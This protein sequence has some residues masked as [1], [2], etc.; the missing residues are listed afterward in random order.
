MD[1]DIAAKVV[2]PVVMFVLGFAVSRFTM[3]KKERS[4]VL[5]Q[6]QNKY[7]EIIRGVSLA[8]SE[9]VSSIAEY[10]E[11]SDGSRSLNC[12]LSVAQKGEAYFCQMRSACAALISG[13]LDDKVAKQ[14]LLPMVKRLVEETL[15]DHYKTL[16]EIAFKLAIPYAGKL[17]RNDYASIYHVYDQYCM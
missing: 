7:D 12:F 14:D 3:T 9:Y 4:D 13:R 16:E 5:F 6:K 2:I 17:N 10:V 15:P 1:W 8:Y 11:C